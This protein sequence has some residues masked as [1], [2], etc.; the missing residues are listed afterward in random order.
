ML[1]IFES[2]IPLCRIVILR[3]SC[4]LK[5]W[6][7]LFVPL[8]GIGYSI[9]LFSFYFLFLAPYVP[10]LSSWIS[11]GFHT[12]ETMQNFSHGLIF[13]PLVPSMHKLEDFLKF[14]FLAKY[15]CVYSLYVGC[16]SVAY[17]CICK[18]RYMRQFLIFTKW[19]YLN[20]FLLTDL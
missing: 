4:S 11:P 20:S 17:L 14:I 10:I 13:C 9:F 8:F 5:C 3:V 16:I 15:W 12:W 18:C 2:L 6:N 1:W 7:L 19:M